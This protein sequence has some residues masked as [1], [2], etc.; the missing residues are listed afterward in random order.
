MIRKMSIA[1]MLMLALLMVI[2]PVSA[3]TTDIISFD[4]YANDTLSTDL[5]I[6]GVQF[7]SPD[8]KIRNLT[9]TPPNPYING[10]VLRNRFDVPVANSTRTLEIQ[11]TEARRYYK[12][13]YLT[14][15][16]AGGYPLIVDG[17]LHGE[18]VFTHTFSPAAVPE[19]GANFYGGFA[20]G[21][22]VEF[23]R[24]VHTI[25]T[26]GQDAVIDDI[27]TDTTFG[28]GRINSNPGLDWAP[29]HVDY[30]ENETLIVRLP[31]GFVA[32]TIPFSAFGTP[33]ASGFEQIDFNR[34]IYVDQAANG[35]V[36]ITGFQYDPYWP[37]SGKPY[38]IRINPDC[39]NPT[40]VS[41]YTPSD[42]TP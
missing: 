24:L 38:V 31:D 27:T 39:T 2:S 25:K 36:Y 30:C 26:D 16:T 33:P 14:F 7:N 35:L 3:Q 10:A 17:Y 20:E 15:G 18:L 11:F 28:D 19:I 32:L 21:R 4:G 29:A 42:Y 41:P 5:G 23:D 22:D 6:T 8:W 40:N 34:G 1:S 9:S 37:N 12:Y 13:S